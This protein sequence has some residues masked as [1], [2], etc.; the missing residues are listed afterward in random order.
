MGG[1]PVKPAGWPP[2][3]ALSGE[4]SSNI[5]MYTYLVCI[6]E[7]NS[8]TGG[9]KFFTINKSCYCSLHEV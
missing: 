4:F 2:M 5:H 9:T 3:S 7:E 6:F 1:Q 8:H